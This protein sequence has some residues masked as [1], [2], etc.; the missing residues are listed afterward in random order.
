[1]T[2]A[3]ESRRWTTQQ[4]LFG[5]EGVD[6]G[7]RRSAW[8]RAARWVLMALTALIG[9]VLVVLAGWHLF[10][11]SP[12]P[13]PIAV[14]DSTF[15][16]SS[17][18]VLADADMAA[19]AYADGQ[20][21]PIPGAEDELVILGDFATATG[22]SR[23]SVAAPNSV[24]GWPGATV[25]D[26]A[27]EFAYVVATR[28]SLEASIDSVASVYD[29]MPT[30]TTLTTIDLRSTTVVDTRQVCPRPNSVDISPANDWLVI[31][32]GTDDGQL[33][34]VTLDQGRPVTSQRFDLDLPDVAERNI[35]A[36]LTYADIH[37]D[38]NA[39]GV[40]ISNRAVALVIFS[41]DDTGIPID[42]AIEDAQPPTGWLTMGRWT[43]T[44]DH[45]LVADVGWGPN[46]LDAVLNNAG[47]ID[48]YAL[49]PDDNTRGIVSS[50]GVSKSPEGFELSNDGE[51]LVA[52]NMERTYLPGGL[53]RLVPG[54]GAS[55]LSLVSVDADTG[56]LDTLGPPVGFRGV[57]P[58]DVAFD[59]DDDHLAVAVYQDHDA[60]T[61][62]GWI[63]YFA[64]EEADD[65]PRITRTGTTTPMPRGAHDLVAIN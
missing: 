51:L 39:A 1:M 62:N 45:F 40:I 36:G 30:G 41:L 13:A 57:L 10:D 65:G 18:L 59:R 47:S 24:M 49:A 60:P 27:G 53:T 64:I 5:E 3:T 61:S 58:E 31:A 33:E 55:S 22:P 23:T 7:S 37:P 54:R 46:P 2:P 56:E 52:V 63:E 34:V 43:S 19:T 35:D 42:A 38:G 9:V 15:D 11:Y 44:G 14:T 6:P 17:L 29:D 26:S 16:V 12:A 32:C 21:H 48:S 20:L 4:R 8:R 28:G 50:A 25:V